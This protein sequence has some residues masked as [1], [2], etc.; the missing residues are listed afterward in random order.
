MTDFFH[1]FKCLFVLKEQLKKCDSAVIKTIGKAG[2][3]LSTEDGV[4]LC[5]ICFVSTSKTC[6]EFYNNWK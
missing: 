3:V 6:I 1:L 2:F 5:R 4:N